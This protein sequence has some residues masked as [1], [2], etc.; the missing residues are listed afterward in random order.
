MTE[1]DWIITGGVLLSTLIGGYRGFLREVLSVAAW[2][3]ALWVAWQT[4]ADHVAPYLDFLGSPT[5]AALVAFGLAFLAV[6]LAATVASHLVYRLVRAAGLGFVDR[7]L[8]L[9]FGALRALAIFVA[10]AY[11]IGGTRLA[12]SPWWQNSLWADDLQRLGQRVAAVL[13]PDL[14]RHLD[15]R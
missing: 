2:L 1:L 15:D 3:A 9:A 11:F 7:T 10:A 5:A 6:L 4:A 14:A 13:P 8:G 12:Q